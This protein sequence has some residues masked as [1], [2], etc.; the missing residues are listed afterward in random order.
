MAGKE[1]VSELI[2]AKDLGSVDRW[3]LPSFDEHDELHLA[4]A[5]K[6]G[7]RGCA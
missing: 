1:P 7:R 2:R 6:R 5:C 3:S 4:L